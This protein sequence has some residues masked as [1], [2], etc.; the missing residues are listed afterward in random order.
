MK[1]YYDYSGPGWI[2]FKVSEKT[3]TA[4]L[5][6]DVKAGGGTC[7]GADSLQYTIIGYTNVDD[8]NKAYVEFNKWWNDI[9]SNGGSP[10]KG[11]DIY[12]EEPPKGW[13]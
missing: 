9:G 4:N 11:G 7:K 13:S 8:N 6:I 3:T 2:E 10:F 1:R 5:T 12:S